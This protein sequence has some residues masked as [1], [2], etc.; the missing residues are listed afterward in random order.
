MPI[1]HKRSGM[2]QQNRL[3]PSS[4]LPTLNGK[5]DGQR[6]RG[7]ILEILHFDGDFGFIRRRTDAVEPD[8]DLRRVVA[9]HEQ[10]GGQE[11]TPLHDFF[12]AAAI[13]G[14]ASSWLVMAKA[15]TARIERLYSR[16]IAALPTNHKTP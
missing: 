12:R 4:I 1:Q 2:K 8:H 10:A 16:P 5:R 7:A 6:R 9:T 15:T 11:Q 14:T 3:P 13:S